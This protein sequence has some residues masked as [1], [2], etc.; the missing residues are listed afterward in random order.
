MKKNKLKKK[1]YELHLKIIKELNN[2]HIFLQKAIPI[3]KTEII[4]LKSKS[5]SEKDRIYQVPTRK[6]KSLSSEAYRTDLEVKRILN[7]LVNRELYENILVTN[8]SK[9]ESFMFEIIKLTMLEYPKK[10]TIGVQGV[11]PYKTTPVEMVLDNN[12][13]DKL[14]RDIIT[15]RIIEVSY[16]KP[17]AYLEYFEKITGCKT[18]NEE[19][20]LYLELKATRDLIIHNSNKINQVYL[21]KAKE[22]KRGELGE[23]ITIDSEYFDSSIAVMKRISGIIRSE[24]SPDQKK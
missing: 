2:S 4:S 9:F 15:E 18:Q 1:I 5:N 19:F 16:S 3:I 23:I 14:L 8:I 12:D 20:K 13:Y 10:L 21:D 6:R 11:K 22:N 24:L 7:T 17:E